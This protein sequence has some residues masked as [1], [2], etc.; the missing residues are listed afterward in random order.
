MNKEIILRLTKY[1]RLLNKLKNLGLERV[2]SNNLSDPIG[3]SSALVRKDFSQ[4][5]IIGQKRGGY[6]IESLIEK[7]DVILGRD[8]AKNVIIVGSGRIGSAL[9]EYEGFKT[10]NINIIAAFDNDPQIINSNSNIPILNFSEIKAFSKD[11]DID[12]AIIAVPDTEARN[13]FEKLKAL[14]IRGFLNFAPRELRCNSDCNGPDC[15]VKCIIHNVNIGLELEHIF[16][17][18]RFKEEELND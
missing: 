2:F 9:L 7:L 3:I 4:L 14:G 13:V 1:R 15:P 5:G 18:L 10:E 12:V 16:Y 8:K 11:N 17:Q 6:E